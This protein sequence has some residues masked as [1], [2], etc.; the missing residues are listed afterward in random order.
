MK[1]GLE[2]VVSYFPD[3][4]IKREDLAY[5]DSAVPEEMAGMFKG[6]VGIG[7]KAAVT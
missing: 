6:A 2:A 5:L 3:S 1:V 7:I 4:V